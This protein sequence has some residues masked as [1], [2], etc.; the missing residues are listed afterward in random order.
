VR[1]NQRDF[2]A[3]IKECT[4]ALEIDPTLARAL[5]IR[6]L[7]YR[8]LRQRERA[9]ADQ[10]QADRLLGEGNVRPRRAGTRTR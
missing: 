5:R 4:T 7:A 1:Y 9:R 2:A 8:V 6:S 10:E 3:A